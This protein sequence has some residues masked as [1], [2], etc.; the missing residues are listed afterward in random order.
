M[1]SLTACGF[2]IGH[3]RIVLV[4]QASH[5]L[6]ARRGIPGRPDVQHG[7]I[8]IDLRQRP[9]S[10]RLRVFAE[11]RV[12][13]GLDDADDLAVFGLGVEAEPLPDRPPMPGQYRRAIVSF[14]IAT[15]GPVRSASPKSR[16]R[17]S[18]M[19]WSRSTRHRRRW[20]S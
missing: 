5:G 17:T 14:T 11:R 18:A 3:A 13:H 16:P 6:D 4:D 15:G 8:A 2:C 7:G 1:T 20:S 10:G 19:P 9:V 12:L